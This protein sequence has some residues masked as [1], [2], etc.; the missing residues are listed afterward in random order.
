MEEL[1]SLGIEYK[2]VSKYSTRCPKCSEDRRKQNSKSLQVYIEPPFVRFRCFHGG[3]CEYNATQYIKIGGEEVQDQV[4]QIKTDF[5]PVPEGLKPPVPEGSL[6][7][8]Y[9]DRAG[10]LLYY[11]CRTPDKRFIPFA[12]TSEGD[13]VARRPNFKTLYRAEKLNA[14]SR[15]VI[16]VEGEK[17]AEAASL[18]FTKADVVTWVGGAGNPQG[19]DWSLIKGREVTIWPDNDDAGRKA[20]QHISELIESDSISIVNVHK[21][22]AKADLADQID[23]ELVKELYRNR[24][25]VALAPVIRGIA[26]SRNLVTDL[27]QRTDGIPFGWSNMDKWIRLPHSGILVVQGRTNHGKSAFMLNLT[28]NLLNNTDTNVLFVSYEISATDTELKLV[29]ILEGATYSK[30]GYENDLAYIKNMESGT[31][32]GYRKLVEYSEQGRLYLT[33]EQVT[34]D[35]IIESM[36]RL[37]RTGKP[38]V[39]VLDYFQLIP[40]GYSGKERYQEVK[41]SIEKLRAESNKLGQLVVG[42]SQLTVTDPNNPF[43]DQSRESKDITFTAELVLKVWNKE[44]AETTGTYK[45]KKKDG[46]DTKIDF[47]DAIQGNFIIDVLKTRQGGL[48]KKFGFNLVDGSRIVECTDKYKEF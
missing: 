21:L 7:Y 32:E 45:T 3:Q 12:Y 19:G 43:A 25:K 2:P 16:V 9:R 37:S 1:E 27:S 18:I 40:A 34:T 13:F 4:Q 39:I 36:R 5:Q 17:A 22:P 24:V 10:M 33:D 38:T 8:E 31:S 30:V 44:A 29:K 11:V 28:C 42:G 15:P 23:I 41:N 20:A 46:E 48:G 14:D 26:N 6:L 35:E 47:Y